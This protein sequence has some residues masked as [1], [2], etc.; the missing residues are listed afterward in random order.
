M[1]DVLDLAQEL[2]LL[3]RSE[4]TSPAASP[5]S[6]VPA[7]ASR[8]SPPPAHQQ[9]GG[10][11]RPS[12]PENDLLA[13]FSD[14][15]LPLVDPAP[16]QGGSAAAGPAEAAAALLEPHQAA[17]MPR[18]LQPALPLLVP[19][20]TV[21]AHMWAQQELSA[22]AAPEAAPPVLLTPACVQPPQQRQQHGTAKR[23]AGNLGP[24]QQQQQQL[25]HKPVRRSSGQRQ[26]PT[27]GRCRQPSRRGCAAAHATLHR[28]CTRSAARAASIPGGAGVAPTARQPQLQ[29]QVKAAQAVAAALLAALRSRAAAQQAEEAAA[30][31]QR[32]RRMLE[33][34][35]AEQQRR[36]EM[37]QQAQLLQL[38]QAP[39]AW[40]PKRAAQW[41]PA[42]LL[43][44]HQPQ[45]AAAAQQLLPVDGQP[46]LPQLPPLQRMISAP[47]Q[48]LAR[49][50]L[51]PLQR[52]HSAPLQ[53][54]AAA[55]LEPSMLQRTLSL[56][57]QQQ[58]ERLAQ[59]RA[60]Q[61]Q[62]ADAAALLLIRGGRQ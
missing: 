24:R 53:R 52:T 10:G 60:E 23:Q 6:W 3:P 32:Q 56:R 5:P 36:L 4:P 11:E 37:A 2:G 13:L 12:Q 9:H 26:P 62:W 58:E 45:P 28:P 1:P 40:Q 29:L 21:S 43:A 54:G 18:T 30:R 59:Q 42:G 46:L 51:P 31:H 44:A 57:L 15:D 34:V 39:L 27:A 17:Q 50:Q 8:A 55:H 22:T 7:L 49:P 41:P 25:K 16:Q 33:E 38:E 48:R 47:V 19:A 14:F 35:Q 61:Q 20:G